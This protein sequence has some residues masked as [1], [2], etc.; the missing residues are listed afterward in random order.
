VLGDRLGL[1]PP[2][3]DD[4]V[5]YLAHLGDT[6]EAA[7][8]AYHIPVPA[9]APAPATASK[10]SYA[11]DVGSAE[12]KPTKTLGE[13]REA[14]GLLDSMIK[15]FDEAPSAAEEYV[16]GIKPTVL[17]M[18]DRISQYNKCSEKQMNYI[19]NMRRGLDKWMHKGSGRR[20]DRYRFEEPDSPY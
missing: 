19:Q 15:D 8:P 13:V 20:E 16:E 4:L 9:S 2:T 3:P 5:P 6:K 18:K 12:A 10:S 1:Q 14:L 17:D 11:K 7:R